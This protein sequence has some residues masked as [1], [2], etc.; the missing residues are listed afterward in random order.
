LKA[1]SS[2]SDIRISNPASSGEVG[3]VADAGFIMLSPFIGSW[4]VPQPFPI[5]AEVSTIVYIWDCGVA[6]TKFVISKIVND[7]SYLLAAFGAA[8]S[9]STF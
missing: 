9:P 8:G 5:L 6:P 1:A 2:L 7:I 4:W 3:D